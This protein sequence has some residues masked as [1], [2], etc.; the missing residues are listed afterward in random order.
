MSEL[1][2]ERDDVLA[3]PLSVRFATPPKRDF[4]FFFFF[5]KAFFCH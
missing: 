5:G 3:S 1:L 4:F 2:I